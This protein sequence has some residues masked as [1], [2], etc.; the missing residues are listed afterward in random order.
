MQKILGYF[1]MEEKCGVLWH[2]GGEAQECSGMP[3]QWPA[4]DLLSF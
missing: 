3:R 2:G 4:G 1:L